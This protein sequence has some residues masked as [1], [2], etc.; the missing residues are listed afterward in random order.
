MN[1]KPLFAFSCILGRMIHGQTLWRRLSLYNFRPIP[2]EGVKGAAKIFSKKVYFGRV[3]PP[4]PQDGS[5]PPPL[6]LFSHIPPKIFALATLAVVFKVI[7]V[8]LH[9]KIARNRCPDRSPKTFM[10]C[11]QGGPLGKLTFGG[12]PPGI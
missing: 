9:Q 12:P 8:Y 10:R 7:I 11:Y 4:P 6:N 5:R 2:R 1:V 3:R